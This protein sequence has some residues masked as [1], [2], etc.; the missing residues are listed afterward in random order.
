MA[1]TGNYYPPIV[2]D[3]PDFVIKQDA[4][5]IKDTGIPAREHHARRQRS[6]E[7]Q[8]P[9]QLGIHESPLER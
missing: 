5:I 3:P 2:E 9:V 4:S 1:K 8:R 7:G 6:G